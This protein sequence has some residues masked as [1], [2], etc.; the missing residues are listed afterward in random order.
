MRDMPLSLPVRRLMMTP[1]P[2]RSS[3]GFSTMLSR[4]AF[5][6]ALTV[7]TPTT[8][9]T[10]ATSGSALITPATRCCRRDISSNDTEGSACVTAMMRP[11]SCG[12]RKPLGMT[13]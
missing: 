11:V 8:E 2:A 6:V 13:T 5:G 10:P 4:P 7:P 3:R 1:T 9:E 12:G